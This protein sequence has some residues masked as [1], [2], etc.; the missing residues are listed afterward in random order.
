MRLYRF[1]ATLLLG[2]RLLAELSNNE[3]LV[4]DHNALLPPDA[5]HLPVGRAV[6]HKIHRDAT[7]PSRLVLPFTS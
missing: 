5:F 7:H 1:A 6:T 3:P 2:H 4:D